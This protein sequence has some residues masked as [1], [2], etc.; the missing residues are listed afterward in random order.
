MEALLKE[1]EP[2]D[3]SK[4]DEE[5][6]PQPPVDKKEESAAE[7][8]AE[9][10]EIL[11]KAGELSMEDSKEET[12]VKYEEPKPAPVQHGKKEFYAVIDDDPGLKKFEGHINERIKKMETYALFYLTYLVG[13][14]SSLPQKVAS[15]PL[16]ENPAKSLEL[17]FSLMAISSIKNGLHVQKKSSW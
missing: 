2:K 4:T 15:F 6:V 17:I 3:E 9:N 12:K 13:R 16:Q 1:T 5:G 8:T 11:K 14:T 10:A 7:P